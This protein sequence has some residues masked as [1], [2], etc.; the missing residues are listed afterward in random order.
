MRAAFCPS[1]GIVE[2][3]DVP[4]PEPGAGEVVVRVRACGVCGS[5]LHWYLGA[6]PAPRVCP[7]HEIAGEVAACGRDVRGVSEG[8]RVAVEPMVVCRECEYCRTGMPQRC[9]HLRIIGLQRDGGFADAVRVPAYG[10]FRLPAALDWTVGALAEPTAVCVHAMRLGGVGLG[11]RVLVLGAG[12]IGLLAVLTAR[13]AGAAD[14]V[15]S[16]RHPHQAAMARRLGANRVFAASDEGAV[17]RAAYV[18]DHPVD[19]VIETIG[20]NADT[21]AEG[22]LA[23]RPGGAV[24]VLGVFAALPSLPAL[25]L[26]VK[27]VRVVGAM[28]YDRSGRR[29]DFDVAL[30]LLERSGDVH[31]LITH[32]IGLDVVQT[33]F[34]TAADKRNGAIKVTVVP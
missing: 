4:Q 10:L 5:D 29:A 3:R 28:L 1:A 23:V 2:L 18:A 25:P 33:A 26:I 32:R 15:I 31:D 13:A 17:K 21:I 30:D 9:P 8:D 24:V 27:E 19:V 11:S 6:L 12:T 20:G 7:G 34:A 16:A 22:V 14:V